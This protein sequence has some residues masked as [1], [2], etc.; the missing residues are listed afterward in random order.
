[1]PKTFW[2]AV[3]A[4][5]FTH[6]KSQSVWPSLSYHQAIPPGAHSQHKDT[7]A[8]SVVGFGVL[9]AICGVLTGDVQATPGNG[10][11]VLIC[12]PTTGSGQSGNRWL[13][14]TVHGTHITFE[15]G[16]GRTG[17]FA[18]TVVLAVLKCHPALVE[19]ETRWWLL[20]GELSRLRGP[21]TPAQPTFTKADLRQASNDSDATLAMMAL[22][23]S[24]YYSMKALFSVG[25]M[26][27]LDVE[28]TQATLFLPPEEFTILK[29][30]LPTTAP[31]PSAGNT[32]L[33]ELLRVS[34]RGGRV[35]ITGP[36]GVMKT[37]TAKAAAVRL[38]RPLFVVKGSPNMDDQDFLGG[39]QMVGGKPEWVDGPFTQAFLRA[40]EAPVVLLFDELLRSDPINLSSAVGILDHVSAQE[41]GLMG[42]PHLEEG[43][44]Y[45]LRL[46]NGELVWAPVKN[47]LLIATTNLGDGYIQAGQSIDT[48]LLGRFNLH[49]D[50]EYGDPAVTVALYERLS[51]DP[52][53][54]AHLYS[55]EVETRANHVS[56]SGLLER[57]ANPRV[58]IS[59]LEAIL[60]LVE[61]GWERHEAFRRA[62]ETTL[63][64]F[65]VPRNDFGRL[66][67]AA[68]E[69]LRRVLN[70]QAL[71]LV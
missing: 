65:C 69:D 16:I 63:I 13:G 70:E 3:N 55:I 23:D 10:Q 30:T 49:L 5:A 54:A 33:D 62:A 71:K 44:Y 64:P 2:S 60:A 61:D 26:D 1:M 68:L 50:M 45:L 29:G 34:R 52:Q 66:E 7:T 32:P 25:E 36:T 17:P 46:K 57:E 24:L 48:A 56:R 41:A 14:A 51:S 35:L 9:T 47:V 42:V 28:P 27:H 31:Q 18:L 4:I 11:D 58:V 20:V 37:E 6:T 59:W 8:K 12:Y 53:L 15:G 43:R 19:V 38:E 39:Y 67:P 21:R 22:I 40:Q